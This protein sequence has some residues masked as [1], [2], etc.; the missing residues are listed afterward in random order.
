MLGAAISARSVACLPGLG[1]PLW[2]WQ[3]TTRIL[4]SSC[5]EALAA[6]DSLRLQHEAGDGAASRELLFYLRVVE[7]WME[8]A[9]SGAKARRCQHAGPPAR[10]PA[11]LLSLLRLNNSVK[12]LAEPL[13]RMV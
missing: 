7:H 1:C 6:L 13:F 4:E 3:Q 9:G 5:A 2:R 8:H 10:P 11:R 12:I